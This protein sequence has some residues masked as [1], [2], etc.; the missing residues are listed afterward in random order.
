[1]LTSIYRFI[2][3][4]SELNICKLFIFINLRNLFDNKTLEELFKYA[5][6]KDVFILNIENGSCVKI[7]YEKKMII[8]HDLID[9]LY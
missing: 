7:K 5:I 6:Y 9:Y 4:V 1:V 2:D 3:I 8:D